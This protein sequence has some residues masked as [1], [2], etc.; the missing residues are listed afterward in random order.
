MAITPNRKIG[1]AGQ[2]QLKNL[3][4]LAAA[5]STVADAAQITTKCPLT[6]Y[7]T[8]ADGTK[9]IKLPK[10]V[11]GKSITIVNRDSD[12][13]ILKVYPN[14]AAGIINALAAAAAISMAAKTRATFECV[15]GGASPIWAT[16]PLVPS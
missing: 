4:T 7:A 12:N 8:G 2:A 9:G 16:V 11:I 10:A 15:V 6:V 13:A 3:Q 1:G 5:G 14:E